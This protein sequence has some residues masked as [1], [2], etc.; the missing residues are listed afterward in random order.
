MPLN[1]GH[2]RPVNVNVTINGWVGR[3]QDVA[4]RIVA[5]LRRM[6][7]RGQILDFNFS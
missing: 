6:N 2:G 3:D 4:T 5:E 7:R 1:A